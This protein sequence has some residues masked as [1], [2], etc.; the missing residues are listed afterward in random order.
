MKPIVAA[1][2]VSAVLGGWT[3]QALAQGQ[4]DPLLDRVLYGQLERWLG[5]GPLYLQNVYTW[6]Q[7]DDS[8]DFHAAADNRGS[9]FTLMRVSDMRVGDE[10]GSWLVGGYNPLSWSSSDSWHESRF[11]WQ[12]TGFVFNYT[13]PG[14]YRQVL[15]DHILPS[16]GLRQ[17]YNWP[18]HGPTF[19][20]GPDLLVNDRMDTVLSWQL[21]YGD[22]DFEGR[23]I[24]DG[25][26]GGQYMQLDAMELYSISLVPEPGQTTMLLGGLAGLGA[27]GWLTRRR[28]PAQRAGLAP[29]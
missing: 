12:R 7:G 2:L 13:D 8:L 26:Y 22:P 27:L 1:G 9:T 3:P 21:T 6:E 29:A 18:D 5:A 17:T 25:S 28:W 14:V 4:P 10:D 11:D 24:I 19:G 16:Q 23:S 15:S 20:A